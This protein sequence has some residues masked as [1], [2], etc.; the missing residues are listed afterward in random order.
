MKLNERLSEIEEHTAD[1]K[2]SSDDHGHDCIAL[3]EYCENELIDYAENHIPWLIKNI[4]I[5]T[6][7]ILESKH[8]RSSDPMREHCAETCYACWARERLEEL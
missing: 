6:Q 4:R 7:I 8:K 2:L 5:L 3:R 1:L